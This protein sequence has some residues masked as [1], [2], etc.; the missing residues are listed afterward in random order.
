MNHKLLVIVEDGMNSLTT[1]VYAA[2]A[3]ACA[4]SPEEGGI[5]LL[6]VLPPRLAAIEGMGAAMVRKLSSRVQDDR[7]KTAMAVLEEMKRRAIQEGV[8]PEFLLIEIAEHSGDPLHQIL[9]TGARH[10]C[11]TI[12]VGRNDGAL[13]REFL[14]GSLVTRLLWKPIGFAIWIV[15]RD[16]LPGMNLEAQIQPDGRES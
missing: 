16:A 10:G 7:R 1:L 5:V 13:V 6:Y 12:V 15:E 14:A 3:C 9:E 11:D 4:E 8:R 2:K